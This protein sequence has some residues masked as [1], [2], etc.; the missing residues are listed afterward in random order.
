MSNKPTPGEENYLRE[1][2]GVLA[3]RPG[4]SW[5]WRLLSLF[6]ILAL[7]LLSWSIVYVSGGTR[8]AYVHASYVPI[9]TAAAFF[10]L[11]GGLIGA[12]LAGLAMGPL[13][14]LDVAAGTHQSLANWITRMGFFTLV[15]GLSGF[16]ILR[17]S[18]QLRAIRRNGFYDPLTNLPNR[19]RCIAEFSKYLVRPNP[20]PTILLTFAIANFDTTTS[21]FG[22]Q[23]SD[24]LQRQAAER[25]QRHL[26]NGTRLYHINNGVFALILSASLEKAV[27]LAYPL[28]DVLNE[29]FLIQGVHIWT[30]AHAGLARQDM[31]APDATTVLRA[32]SAALR[33]AEASERGVVVYDAAKDLE[34]RTT[35]S[36]LPDLQ[37][38]LQNTDEIQLYYQPKVDLRTGQCI[39]AEA[40]VR[41]LHP[42]RG[43]IP[44]DQF[45]PLAEKTA[46]IEPLT[47]TV[48]KAAIQQLGCWKTVDYS[49]SLAVN[50]SVRNLE[51]PGFSVFVLDLV[52]SSG[53]NPANLELEITESGL[54]TSPEMVRANLLSLRKMGIS[55]ALDDFG[56]GHSSLSH[57]KDLPA[58]TLKLDRS[59]I[60]DL[61]TD[62]KS[63]LIVGATIQTAH[64]LGFQV[65]A[66]GIEDQR[67][68]DLLCSLS[69]DQGQGYFISKPLPKRE[70]DAWFQSR[71]TRL[72]IV[73]PRKVR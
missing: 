54:I 26:P 12:I 14:P 38:A 34:R 40:L 27:D 58:D 55:I 28:L 46:L 66:E 72:P 24:E 51:T 63:G 39:G 44:P 71:A 50:V 68:Y 37:R 47:A 42:E 1:A 57:L 32:S 49:L 6:L 23:A 59:F 22:H 69:C 5:R 61:E 11:P 17:Q 29:P 7:L 67:T 9:I 36:L 56:T 52:K 8:F 48:L 53:V 20:Q 25:I 70:F 41:W 15:G 43:I 30:G 4:Y 35:L 13:M 21:S 64:K 62:P 31:H 2:A 3:S 33:E 18:R 16:V 45:I 60:R 65:V 10:G 73:G 19:S